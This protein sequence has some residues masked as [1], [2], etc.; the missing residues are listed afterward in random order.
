[1]A[2]PKGHQ[3][4]IEQ[5]LERSHDKNIAA[6]WD[7]SHRYTP[8]ARHRR[9]LLLQIIADL[10]FRDVLDAGC[11]QPHLLQEIVHRYD[12]EGFGCD[13]SDEVI[14][15]NQV[16]IPECQFLTLD[17][18][19]ERWPRERQFDLV[20]SSEVLEHIP[21]WRLALR[22]LV[23]MSR[24]HVLISVPGGTLRSVEQ[25][26]GHYRHYQGPELLSALE[27]A[28][29][30]IVSVRRWGFPMYDLYK[31][32]ISRLAPEKLYPTFCTNERSY[33]TIQK[34]VTH[35]L[36]ALFFLNDRFSAG[37]Q[38]IVLA[39]KNSNGGISE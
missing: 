19:H 12:V 29:C 26:L 14:A 18:T 27:D 9:R 17:L 6:Q 8:T 23:A 38:L 33:S 10:G 15:K 2:T 7:D 13:I 24:K 16:H 4:S 34:L 32:L 35:V 37:D 1:M 25:M 28:G 3:V 5:F 31:L 36:F 39:R 21:D 22:N 20:V 11:A 30:A